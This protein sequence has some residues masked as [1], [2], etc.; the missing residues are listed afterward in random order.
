MSSVKKKILIIFLGKIT[1]TDIKLIISSVAEKY[2]GSMWRE[3]LQIKSEIL[4]CSGGF[5]IDFNEIG[6]SAKKFLEDNNHM[7]IRSLSFVVA[8]LNEFL[9]L[10]VSLR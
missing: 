9:I 10:A 5:L 4:E 1:L 7:E 8:L 6:I 3:F 2:Q